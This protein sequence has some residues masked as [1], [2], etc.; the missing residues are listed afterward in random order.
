M[1]M[2]RTSGMMPMITALQMATASLAVPKSVMKTIVGRAADL[3]AASSLFARLPQ[4]AGSH[5]NANRS[6][7]N[8]HRKRCECM[9]TP[10]ANAPPLSHVSEMRCRHPENDAPPEP[11]KEAKTCTDYS[12]RRVRC[13]PRAVTK[14]LVRGLGA[15]AILLVKIA[16]TIGGAGKLA[17]DEEVAHLGVNLERITSGDNEVGNFAGFERAEPI[18][19]A[20][21]LGGVERYSLQGFVMWQAVRDR[22]ASE[23]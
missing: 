21:H 5:A 13:K 16:V 11:P 10:S 17:I 18:S 7:A 12:A 20:E 8:P 19:E 1:S 4:P 15:F 14:N 22:R 2:M 6:R 3:F 23:L 9:L